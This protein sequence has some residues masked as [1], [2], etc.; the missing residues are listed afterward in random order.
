M[1]QRI[2]ELFGKNLDKQ[3][4]PIETDTSIVSI[5]GFVGL[6]PMPASAIRCNISW[7]TA[8]TCVTPT[9]TRP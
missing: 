6:P 2:C 8:A 9:S 7:S 3:L 4:I 5:N 1:K